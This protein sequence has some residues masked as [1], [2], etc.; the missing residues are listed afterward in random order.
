MYPLNMQTADAL[1]FAV[2]NDATEHAALTLAGYLPGLEQI[3]PAAEPD[4]EPKRKPGRPRKEQ[5]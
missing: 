5:Q 1:G 3:A 2:A 4:A